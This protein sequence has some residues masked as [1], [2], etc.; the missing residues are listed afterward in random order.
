MEKSDEIKYRKRDVFYERRRVPTRLSFPHDMFD[1]RDFFSSS[2]THST[3]SV[4]NSENIAVFP[5]FLI[6]LSFLLTRYRI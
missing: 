2:N 4:C 3:V 1:V 6:Q 5:Q